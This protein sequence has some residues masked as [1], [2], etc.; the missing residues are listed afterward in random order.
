MADSKLSALAAL[1][2][3]DAASGD[4]FYVDDVSV[5]TGKSITRDELKIALGITT[6]TTSTTF[7]FNGSGGTSS[8][9][10][11]TWQKI[12]NFVTLNIPTVEATTGTSSTTFTSDTAIAAAVRP[13]TVQSHQGI[14]ISNNGTGS[15]SV[16]NATMQTDGT[17]T[18]SRDKAATAWTDAATG[19]VNPR[20]TVTYWVG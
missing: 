11:L 19:G 8:A 9:V 20:A 17:I 14:S 10:T 12:G 1:A 5:T 7:T 3:T 6:G 2:G 4:L 13:T 16:G 18:I 15:T